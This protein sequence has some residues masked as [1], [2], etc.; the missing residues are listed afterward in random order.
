MIPIIPLNRQARVG[1]AFV[2]ALSHESA[3]G[4]ALA[5]VSHAVAVP[6]LASQVRPGL[7]L[8]EAET[9]DLLTAA[10]RFDVHASGCFAAG[11][12][13]V[14]VWS[15]PFD[16]P[17]TD[18][19]GSAALLGSVNWTYDTPVR[20]YVTVYRAMVTADGVYCGETTASIL[21]RVLALAGV[22]VERAHLTL[23]TPPSRDPFR[24]R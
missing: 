7:V 4:R 16:F 6:A 20:H 24:P 5:V 17:G 13:G 11:P 12:A 10:R 21:A 22:P 19:P 14:Q 2:T 8:P 23:P 3:A 15:R 18:D 1:R 9:R